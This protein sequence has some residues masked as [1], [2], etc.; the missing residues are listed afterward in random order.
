M[1]LTAPRD[2]PGEIAV[3]GDDRTARIEHLLEKARVGRRQFKMSEPKIRHPLDHQPVLVG[4]EH[5]VQR[6]ARVGGEKS[7]CALSMRSA[8]I[9]ALNASAR[10]EMDSGVRGL[11]LLP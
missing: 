2:G 6:N 1:P 5:V 11:K 9:H 3:H 10:P 8:S 4:I 7:R